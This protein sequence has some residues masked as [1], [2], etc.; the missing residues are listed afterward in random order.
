MAKTILVEEL[1]KNEVFEEPIMVQSM[2][3]FSK[4]AEEEYV[5]DDLDAVYYKQMIAALGDLY[6]DLTPYVKKD[7]TVAMEADLDAGGFNLTNVGEVY[8]NA[9]VNKKAFDL[10]NRKAYDTNGNNIISFQDVA[11]G[12]GFHNAAGWTAFFNPEDLTGTENFKIPNKGG[13]GG[14]I[15]VVSDIE[16]VLPTLPA[17]DG[18]SYSLSVTDEVKTFVK[19]VD[20]F[21]TPIA[22]INKLQADDASNWDSDG[23]WT[24]TGGGGVITLGTDSN[25]GEEFAG[26]EV[27]TLDKYTYKC[28]SEGWRRQQRLV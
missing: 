24:G 7:G 2:L 5:P 3:R 14:T 13:A 12:V 9:A 23:L 16:D 4:E 6:P 26:I 27:S 19:D 21:S 15:A 8:D 17:I 11:S 18:Y 28:Y 20:A 25:A 22:I 10:P 1:K